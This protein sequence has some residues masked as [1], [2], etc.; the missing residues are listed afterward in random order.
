MDQITAYE[1]RT[2][3]VELYSM[4]GSTLY[5]WCL[6]KL[7]ENI[8]LISSEVIPTNYDNG[9]IPV[10][11]QIFNFG[12]LSAPA[13]PPLSIDF[14]LTSVI[15]VK[16]IKDRISIKVITI[17]SNDEENSSDN[18]VKYSDNKAVY[19][20]VNT[21]FFPK[22]DQAVNT[23][24][25]PKAGQTAIPYGFPKVDWP[26]YPAMAYAYPRTT[27]PEI[28]LKYGYPCAVQNDPAQNCEPPYMLEKYGYPCAVQNDTIVK[29]GYPCGV[30]DA[31][32]K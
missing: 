17:P 26:K 18:F 23:P 10:V 14:V 31:T 13:G 7:P 21:P 6:E 1:G 22:A 2:F 11:V 24:F 9:I 12:V 30:K 4:L 20:P 32:N 5:G 28:V 15:D 29:Y 25:F 19:N 3:T 16:D 8:I 27:C